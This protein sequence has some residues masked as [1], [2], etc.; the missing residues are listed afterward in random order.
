MDC[1]GALGLCLG[2]NTQLTTHAKQP[3]PD[4]NTFP[5]FPGHTQTPTHQHTHTLTNTKRQAEA[6]G[7]A[8]GSEGVKHK[9]AFAHVLDLLKQRARRARNIFH[10]ACCFVC[11]CAVSVMFMCDLHSCE[12]GRSLCAM[13]DLHSCEWGRWLCWLSFCRARACLASV[14]S[15]ICAHN[16]LQAASTGRRARPPLA[17]AKRP[18]KPPQHGCDNFPPTP[19]TTTTHH[20]HH[21]QSS[22]QPFRFCFSST[23]GLVGCM[24]RGVGGSIWG[25]ILDPK[26]GPQNGA[27]EKKGLH[28]PQMLEEGSGARQERP[29]V[30]NYPSRTIK[31]K[32]APSNLVCV[33]ISFLYFVFS[34]LLFARVWFTFF[35]F[36]DCIILTK[37]HT[38]VFGLRT[39]RFVVSLST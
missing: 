34:S 1:L 5:L 12:W 13:R 36:L 15:T 14:L 31:T 18:S 4:N 3:P 9:A 32:N 16:S 11:V 2:L 8:E 35:F 17:S 6:E 10:S 7:I 26:R 28:S 27:T 39:S 30:Y 21:H 24:A 29:V 19:P 20:H 38:I 37:T 25:S 33:A 22:Y 23:D